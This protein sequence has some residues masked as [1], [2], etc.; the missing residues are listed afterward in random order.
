MTQI[1]V[2]HRSAPGPKATPAQGHPHGSWLVG[3]S[4]PMTRVL[5]EIERVAPTEATVLVV[6]ESGTGKELAARALHY[7]SPRAHGPFVCVNCAALPTELFESELFGH[8]KG[9]FTGAIADRKGRFEEARGGTLVLD[10]IGTLPAAMQS[11]LLRVLDTFEFQEVG[12]SVTRRADVRIIAATNEDLAQRARAGT[13]RAD[14]FYRLHVFPLVIPPLRERKAD[15]PELA[16]A[17][18]AQR[19]CSEI[20]SAERLTPGFLALLQEHDWPGNVR[21]L[22]NLLERLEILAGPG[23]D[24][25]ALARHILALSSCDMPPPRNRAG[26][27][28]RRNLEALGRELLVEALATSGGSKK[29]AASLLGVDARNLGYYLRRHGLQDVRHR[30]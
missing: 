9:A 12:D 7:G 8:R 21:E 24:R 17:L 18:L 27:H 23:A 3:S 5:A 4:A 20:A 14:L 6:G 25:E 28:L 15:I 29:V 13:F 30:A 11:K 16:R 2:L 22:K 26:L 19:G 1:D 10:E